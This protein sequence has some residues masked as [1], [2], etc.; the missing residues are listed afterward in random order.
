[1]QLRRIWFELRSSLWFRPALWVVALALTAIGLISLERTLLPLN[2]AG[3]PWFVTDQ[4]SGARTMLGSISTA[5][6]TVTSLVFS[7]TMVAVVQTANVYSPRILRE[8]L[9]DTSNHH[10]LGILI[11]TFLYSLIVL[12]SIESPDAEADGPAPFVPTYATN[13]ALL[14]SVC[15]IGAFIYFLD[16]VAHSIKVNNVITLILTNT[17]TLAKD[18]FPQ[19]VGQGWPRREPPIVPREQPIHVPAQADG[20]VQMVDGAGLVTLAEQEDVVIRLER[21]IGDYVRPATTIATV[22]FAESSADIAG[23]LR[24]NIQIGSEQTLAQNLLFGL[25]QLSDI[26]LRALSPSTNDPA[27]ALTCID[28]LSSVL[29]DLVDMAPISPYRCDPQGVLRVIAPTITFAQ[30]LQQSFSQIRRYGA[31]DVEVVLRLLQ[32]ADALADRTTRHAYRTDLAE[33]VQALLESADRAID[34]PTDRRRINDAICELNVL[35]NEYIGQP[36]LLEIPSPERIAT[37]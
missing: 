20:Y 10:V 5:M 4:A 14:L 13:G 6:L 25:R 24:Q 36:A 34:S 33:F 1:M 22:W 35:C 27:T 15:S 19:S 21:Q 9:S 16:H 37:G 7:I 23:R 28:A 31:S 29:D 11:G 17:L 8:Y 3:L 32:I 18:P 2:T 12:R 26:A 30:T